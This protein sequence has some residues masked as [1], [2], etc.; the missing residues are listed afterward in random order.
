MGMEVILFIGAKSVE[1]IV[2]TISTEGPMENLVKIAQAISA[3][4]T[5]I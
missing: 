4:K 1:H 3:K 2:N 5:N